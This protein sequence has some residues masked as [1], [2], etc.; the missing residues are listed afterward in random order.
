MHI[1]IN[2]IDFD[3]PK[4]T[5]QT[6][7]WDENRKR[8][9]AQLNAKIE[10]PPITVRSNGRSLTIKLNVHSKDLSLGLNTDESY[11]LTAKEKNGAGYVEI[12]AN[13]VFGARHGLETLSQLIVYDDL[14]N[15]YQMVRDIEIT[16]APAFKYRGIILDTSRNFFSVASIKRTLDAMAMTKLNSF[17]WHIT[18]THSFPM[19]LKSHPELSLLGAY[20]S[21]KVYSPEDIS[22][23]VRYGKVRGVRVLPEFDAPAHVGEGWQDKGLTACFNYQPWNSYCVEPPCGQ[24]DVTK[25]KLYDMLEDI[26]KEMFELFDRPDLF[27]MGGDEVS[28]GC[29]NSSVDIQ[30][31]MIEKNWGLAHDDFLKLWGY[32]QEK[33]LARFDKIAS[34]DTRI[35]LWTS[36]L[37]EP[38]YVDTYLNKKRYIIQVWTT[39]TDPQIMNLLERGYDLIISNYDALYLDCGFGGWVNDGNNW[40]SP[41]I[42]WQKIYAN[43]PTMVGGSGRFNSQILG[44]EAALWSEQVDEWSLDARLWPRSSALGERLWTNPSGSWREADSRMLLHRHRLVENGIGAERLQP[45][46]CL[47]NENQCPI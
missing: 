26:Y 7:F 44:A 21:Y 13:T 11:N 39:A 40:C 37:T 25:D 35:I 9:I 38:P 29:W 18:D 1:D 24:F 8:F 22:E 33:A 41:Y 2:Q 36:K 3:T 16:D 20:S 45:E 28:V 30:K 10:G 34:R 42:G 17:H 47:L 46:W 15:E 5:N 14:R 6:D 4:V 32:F 31:W 23:I 19:G 12:T 27:H 43:S